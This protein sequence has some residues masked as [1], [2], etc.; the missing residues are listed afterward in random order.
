MNKK[1]LIGVSYVSAWVILWGTI[2][3]LIDFYFLQNT[4]L[5]GS[6]GQFATF[7]ITAFLSSIIA[8]YIF[9]TINN[10]FIS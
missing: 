5:P 4:Y 1:T 9:P 2:G 10:K 3:S 7:I 6:I 8:I